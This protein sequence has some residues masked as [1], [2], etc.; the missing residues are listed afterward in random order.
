MQDEGCKCAVQGALVDGETLK[1]GDL[2]V[3]KK[4]VTPDS[5]KK[6]DK[7]KK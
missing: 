3:L 2:A 7:K 5:T 1:K 6:D 4:P